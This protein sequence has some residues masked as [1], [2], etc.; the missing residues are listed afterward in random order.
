[1]TELE[2]Q[3]TVLKDA[4]IQATARSGYWK[5]Q[6][7]RKGGHPSEYEIMFR[8]T[9]KA[10]QKLAQELPGIDWEAKT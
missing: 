2:N 9:R 10:R 4:L 3:I 7:I 5:E 1:M 8:D 6:Y